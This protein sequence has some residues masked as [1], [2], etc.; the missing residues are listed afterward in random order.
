MKE[1]S[2]TLIYRNQGSQLEVLLVH[3]SGNYNKRA[4]WGIPKGELDVGESYEQAARRETMEE[5]GITLGELA[6]LGYIEYTKSRKRV[7]CFTAEASQ[8]A[9]A[10]CASWEIDKC[11]FLQV[12]EARRL[13]HADQSV[14]LDRLIKHLDDAQRK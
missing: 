4:P 7:H 13:I 2:G 9:V 12:E 1:S 8:N 11:E 14:F 10:S 6:S 5:T 3:P